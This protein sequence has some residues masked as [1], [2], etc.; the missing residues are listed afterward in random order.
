MTDGKV[1]CRKLLPS[2]TLGRNQNEVI[3]HLSPGNIGQ[4]VKSSA[5]IAP[6]AHISAEH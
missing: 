6:T 4:K 3:I 5:S 2:L 1:A